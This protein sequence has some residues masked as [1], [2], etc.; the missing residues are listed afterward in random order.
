M[1]H[2]VHTVDITHNGCQFEIEKLSKASHGNSNDE[3]YSCLYKAA[4]PSI[5]I[6]SSMAVL[7]T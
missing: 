6:K 7:I 3:Y 4:G 5:D 1:G 2:F